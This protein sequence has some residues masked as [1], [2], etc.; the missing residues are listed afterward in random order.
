MCDVPFLYQLQR[1]ARSTLAFS[2]PA[3]KGRPFLPH[4]LWGRAAV[5]LH[6]RRTDARHSFAVW[7]LA[8]FPQL[9][10]VDTEHAPEGLAETERPARGNP[11][12]QVRTVRCSAT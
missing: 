12:A 9:T 3:Y 4:T 7:N 6:V 11:T 8:S 1:R 5:K 10:S 2:E